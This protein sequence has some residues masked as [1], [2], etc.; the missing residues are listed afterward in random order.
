[1][2]T[3]DR[4]HEALDRCS[5]HIEDGM[6]RLESLDSFSFINAVLEIE[7]EFGIEIP[8][9]LLGED[10]FSSL[11]DLSDLID[12]CIQDSPQSV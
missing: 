3:M 11:S 1:M 6:D 12:S 4:L 8:D 7:N 10:L 5:L 9:H 2:T